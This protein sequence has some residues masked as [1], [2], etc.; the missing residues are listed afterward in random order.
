MRA[1]KEQK[2]SSFS[3]R[4]NRNRREDAAAGDK[5][6]NKKKR[7]RFDEDLIVFI[8]DL[9]TNPDGYQPDKL[10]RVVADIPDDARIVYLSAYENRYV[11]C[12]SSAFLFVAR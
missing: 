11:M 4:I 8:T 9:H 2:V 12:G 1:D 6:R 5:W 10:R 3:Y 7:D